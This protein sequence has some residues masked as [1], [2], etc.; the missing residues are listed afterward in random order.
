M[1][2]D[3]EIC[4]NAEPPYKSGQKKTA[5][6]PVVVIFLDHRL[7]LYHA[8]RFNKFSGVFRSERRN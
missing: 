8:V 1:A 6:G 3:E 4:D 2:E 5:F 7:D